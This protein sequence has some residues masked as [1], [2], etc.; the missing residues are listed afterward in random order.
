M[1]DYLQATHPGALPKQR[2]ELEGQ[3]MPNHPASAAPIHED[4]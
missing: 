2:L 1:I 4:A 3:P